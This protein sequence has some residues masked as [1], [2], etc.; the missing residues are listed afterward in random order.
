[1]TRGEATPF[2]PQLFHR[3]GR[4]CCLDDIRE[5][6]STSEDIE[7]KTRSSVSGEQPG[8]AIFLTCKASIIQQW[9]NMSCTTEI[10]F[11]K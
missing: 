11:K 1:M 10:K 7:L 5:S 9:K 2:R 4:I 3:D 8:L 6:V